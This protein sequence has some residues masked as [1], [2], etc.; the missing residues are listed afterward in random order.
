[1]LLSV[2]SVSSVA[3]LFRVKIILSY[4]RYSTDFRQGFG[5]DAITGEDATALL[6]SNDFVR[7]GLAAH[8][9]RMRKNPTD[10]VHLHH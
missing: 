10:V 2:F 5:G 7:I 3:N 4:E 9:I 6:E 1:M 8:E